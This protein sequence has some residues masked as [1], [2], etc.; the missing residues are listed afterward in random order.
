MKKYLITGHKGQLGNEFVRILEKKTDIELYSFDYDQLDISNA[1]QVM[2]FF[3]KV[4]PDFTINCAAYNLVD[5]AEKNP[6][7]AFKINTIG[8]SNLAFAC[9]KYQS[10]FVHFSSDYVFDGKK[11]NLYTEEDET[12]PLNE[13]GKSKL[14]GE[15][16]VLE[17]KSKNILFRTSW[18]YGNG[19]QNF[20]YKLMEWAKKSD[21]L[22]IAY[23]EMSV[24]TS[25]RTIAQIT[26]KAINDGLNGLFHLTNSDYCSRYEWAC[27]VFKI[28]KK[29]QAIYPVS[30][31]IFS[32][33]AKR[34][35]FSAMSNSKLKSFYEIN[36]WKKE[37]DLFLGQNKH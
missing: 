35:V 3:S 27:E 18:V 14:F 9:E 16:A 25:V 36:D 31:D 28:F 13:Y 17:S 15:N 6:W 23:D 37:L 30:S 33:P 19:T 20:I 8:T 5:N 29:N 7:E 26:L 21:T 11:E 32:L 22:K 10:F 12:N 34:P 4:K 2:D 24:P 1:N